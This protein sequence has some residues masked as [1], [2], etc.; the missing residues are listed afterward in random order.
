MTTATWIVLFICC[1]VSPMMTMLILNGEKKK[2]E[3]A[4]KD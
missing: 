3:N 4:K 1:F 2:K